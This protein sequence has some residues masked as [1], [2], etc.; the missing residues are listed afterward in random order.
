MLRELYESLKREISNF[1]SLNLP[2][3]PGKK[4]FG[5]M[6]EE[7]LSERKRDLSIFFAALSKCKVAMQSKTIKELLSESREAADEEFALWGI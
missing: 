7:F 3:F 5:N 6:D 1:S 2:K 4:W